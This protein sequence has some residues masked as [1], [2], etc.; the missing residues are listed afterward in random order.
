MDEFRPKENRPFFLLGTSSAP[1]SVDAV[2]ETLWREVVSELVGVLVE[3]VRVLALEDAMVVG[4]V[5]VLMGW[6]SVWEQCMF[7]SCLARRTVRKFVD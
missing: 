1:L 5:D 4:C 2:E 7:G 6:R 3:V